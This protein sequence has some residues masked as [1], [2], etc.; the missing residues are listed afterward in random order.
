MKVFV[1][2]FVWWAATTT[3]SFVE[4]AYAYEVEITTGFHAGVHMMAGHSTGLWARLRGP[5]RLSMGGSGSTW[6]QL[7]R[8]EALRGQEVL[9]AASYPSDVVELAKKFH[10]GVKTLILCSGEVDHLT[11]VINTLSIALRPGCRPG[12]LLE[13]APGRCG[14]AMD[15]D[16]AV[17]P[18]WC[19]HY[20]D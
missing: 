14:H 13:G 5:S 12:H 16:G 6:M 15:V 3:L 18:P 17:V 4:T 8:K 2:T 19:A 20:V 11:N 1:A 10:A 9:N 7:P